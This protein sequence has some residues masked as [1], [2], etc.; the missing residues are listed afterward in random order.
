MS[1]FERRFGRYAIPNLSLVMIICYAC[2]YLVQII[3][4]VLLQYLTLNPYAIIR[5]QIWR[6]F[7]WVIIPPGTSNII[8][9]LIMLFFYFSIGTTLERT[10]GTYRYNVYIFSGLFFT[11]VG[12]F[13]MMLISFAVHPGYLSDAG[14]ASRYFA[15]FSMTFSTYYVNMSIFLAYAVTFPD[16][17]V[18]LYFI[19]PLK[20]KWLGIIYGVFLAYEAL[21]SLVGGVWQVTFAMAASLLNFFIFW[22]RSKGRIRAESFKKRE[23]FNRNARRFRQAAASGMSSVTKHKC[24]ICGRTE[25]DSPD[26]QFRFCTKCEGN[27]EYC[28]EHL[29]THKHVKAGD[30][31]GQWNG[32]Q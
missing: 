9:V 14:A 1:E 11:I 20:V 10:W 24:A 6:L 8:F 16:A 32:M 2:G 30:Y 19:I 21:T 5:G 22:R 12:A 25:A 17:V 15:L 28:E 13:L 27:F 23:A 3:S 31:T 7:T 29:Y 26:M 18:L 4:P